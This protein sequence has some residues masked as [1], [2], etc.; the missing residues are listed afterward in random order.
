MKEIL[1]EFCEFASAVKATL[2]EHIQGVH[3]GKKPFKSEF[4]AYATAYKH[5]L[6]EHIQRVH[7]GKKL[8]QYEICVCNFT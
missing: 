6:I 5:H 7:E 4:C 8:F 1:C 2:N 3:E